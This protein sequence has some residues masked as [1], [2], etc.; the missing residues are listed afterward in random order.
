MLAPGAPLGMGG[1]GEGVSPAPVESETLAVPRDDGCVLEDEPRRPPIV[2][3]P[4]EP[5]PEDAI[6]PGEAKLV[7]TARTLQD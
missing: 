6:G 1:M 5:N 4:G 3:Q 2:P 7:A